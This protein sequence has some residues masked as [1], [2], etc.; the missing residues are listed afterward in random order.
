[1][2]PAHDEQANDASRTEDVMI[3]KGIP[4]SYQSSH[5]NESP[6]IFNQSHGRSFRISFTLYCSSFTKHEFHC[7]VLT[8]CIRINLSNLGASTTWQAKLTIWSNMQLLYVNP[9]FNMIWLQWMEWTEKWCATTKTS[10]GRNHRFQ[11]YD[12][13]RGNAKEL[14]ILQNK[15]S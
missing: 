11:I 13:Y 2:P 8:I 1:M 3:R 6:T 9:Q 12:N 5:L 7:S 10:I 15:T 4:P 14:N